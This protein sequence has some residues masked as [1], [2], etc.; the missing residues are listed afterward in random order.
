MTT[1]TGDQSWSLG[2]LIGGP[3]ALVFI[4]LSLVAVA[5]GVVLWRREAD[6]LLFV[7]GAGSLVVTLGITGWAFYPYSSDY[8]K[9]TELTGEVVKVNDRFLQAGKGVEQKY[10]VDFGDGEEYGC[11]DTRCS[12][13]EPGERLTLSCKKAW[14]YTGRDGWD[15]N[16][17]G[18]EASR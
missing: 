14:Q 4:L 11:R 3:V 10:V 15:C 17:V 13:I 7:L 16:Y 6:A 5:A 12:L 1:T 8:H 18:R 2:V 9:W